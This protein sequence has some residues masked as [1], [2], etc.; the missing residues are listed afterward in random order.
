[1][2]RLPE[3]HFFISEKNREKILNKYIDGN[4]VFPSQTDSKT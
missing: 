1:M 4:T 3:K 2:E